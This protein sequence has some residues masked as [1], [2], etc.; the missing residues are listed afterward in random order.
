[1]RWFRHAD[2]R[3]GVGTPGWVGTEPV[4]DVGRAAVGVGLCAD[5]V[6][7]MYGAENEVEAAAA[8]YWTPLAWFR[9]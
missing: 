9:A 7:L 4:V 6:G 2:R 8:W 1:M 5:A 3:H